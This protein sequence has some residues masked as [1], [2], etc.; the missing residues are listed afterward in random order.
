[1]SDVSGRSAGDDSGGTD[2]RRN[3]VEGLGGR[4][5]GPGRV[6]G[7]G[8]RGP[9]TVVTAS[10]SH[11]LSACGPGGSHPGADAGAARSRA[12]TCPLPDVVSE[13]PSRRPQTS[14]PAAQEKTEA[15]KPEGAVPLGTC[16]P[17]KACC[18]GAASADLLMTPIQSSKHVRQSCPL[19]LDL[20]TRGCSLSEELSEV[21]NNRAKLAAC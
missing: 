11:T 6:Q 3:T 21:G 1:M 8:T 16:G 4:A 9:R 2:G 7:Q 19:R 14:S 5:S 18:P 17:R 13:S 10:A 20:F 12:C 15:G